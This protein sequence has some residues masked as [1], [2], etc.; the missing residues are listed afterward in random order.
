[1]GYSVRGNETSKVKDRVAKYC[2][3]LGLDLGCGNV[4]VSDDAIGV[5]YEKFAE[6]ASVIIDLS[7]ENALRMFSNESM[8]FV[9]SSHLLED[10][11]NTKET[12]TEWCRVIKP[13]GYL[14]L[15]VPDKSIYPKHGTRGASPYHKVDLGIDDIENIL[16]N[17]GGWKIISAVVHN[18]Y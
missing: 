15:Y 16:C 5:D 12:L 4:K 18:E 2:V 1:M 10:F 14:I 17:F 3:G 6:A 8:D 11:P 9:F 7:K 13:G